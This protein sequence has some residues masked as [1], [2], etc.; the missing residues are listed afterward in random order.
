MEGTNIDLLKSLQTGF[1]NSSLDS[2]MELR[3]QLLVND[4]LSGRKVLTTIDHE[5]NNCEEFWF[6][7]AFITTGGIATVHQ[8]LIDLEKK[9]V[10]G[11]ILASQYLNFT[12]P[13]ALRKLLQFKNVTLKICDHGNFHGKGYLFKT[14]HIYNLIIGS[15]NFTSNALTSNKEL[16]IKISAGI[17][18][19]L[20]TSTLKE[21]KN[22][23]EKAIEVDEKFIEKY[24]S[25]YQK[26]KSS[27]TQSE[28][29]FDSLTQ[30][31]VMPNSMQKEALKNINNLRKEGKNKALLIS[32]TG[33][34]KTYL[35]AFDVK[36]FNPKKFLF[37]VHRK[38]IAE[39]ALRSF[40]RIFKEG[41]KSMGLFSGDR[42]EIEND[43]IFSTVQ[44]IA[45]EE[46]LKLFDPTYFDY[47]VIDE[48]HRAGAES[49]QRLLNYFNPE[50][51]L[52]MTATPE[53]TD[54]YDMFKLFDHN[55][56]YEIRLHR[57]L[58]EDMLAPFHY[59]GISEIEIEDKVI[60]EDAGFNLL[61]HPDRLNHI[62]ATIKK[63]GTDTGEIRGLVF[64]SKV[65]ECEWFSD[66]FNKAGY[67]TKA[68]SGNSSDKE[69]D[70]AIELL[71]SDDQREKLDYIFTRDI[72]NEGIDIPRVNQVIMLRPTQSA[73]VF[74][75]QLG[76]GLRKAF[77]KEYLTVIDFIGNYN[78]NFLVPI[79]L[80]GDSS[81]NKDSLRKFMSNESRFLPGESTISFDSIAK[82]RIYKAIDSANL[83]PYKELKKDYN[84]LKFK[85]NRIPNMADFLDHGSRDP[86]HYVNYNKSY[87]N[88]LKAI[89]EDIPT[90]PAKDEKLLEYLSYEINNAK[91][92]EE[93]YLLKIL[94]LEKSIT[95][96]EFQASIFKEFG[97]QITNETVA[98]AVSNINLNFITENYNRNLLPI[99]QIHGYHLISL[100]D[101]LISLSKSFSEVLENNCFKSQLEDSIQY[102]ILTYKKQFDL[103]QYKEGFMLYHKYARKDV[104]RILNW[105]QNPLAQNVGGYIISQDKSNCPIFVTYHKDENISNATKYEDG[106]KDN[107]VFEWMSKN[108]R[109]L[110]SP[111]VQSI[112]NHK[113]TNLR[114]PLFIKKS[115]AESDDFYYMGDL[116]PKQESFEQ[117]TINN[118]NG[119]TFSIVKI[120]FD[121][122]PAV[123]DWMLK[124]LNTKG[125]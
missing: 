1:I 7:V 89:N 110:N 5:L 72:F 54:G 53:R 81:Y 111:D 119:S 50:F 45:R 95:D 109:T 23:F 37:V 78:N 92:A 75:Q 104:F 28:E 30:R 65:E 41:I 19:E 61:L 73:I 18:S 33:T 113:A 118:D 105:K 66:Q 96:K 39:E 51:L 99:S 8:T 101:G 38:R 91:R 116:T 83:Q 64:C 10:K 112:K 123:E 6:S 25:I 90:I 97:F 121:I 2:R 44:T 46:N 122:Q 36:Q 86:F 4:F 68:L 16:N 14:N 108:K 115:N 20:I 27:N 120:I 70:A 79:A 85:L 60:E 88:F 13:E 59:Y 12:Q 74:V 57:A 100:E 76:R 80:Y 3:P 29:K 21:F 106:F 31:P 47:I 15:S 56:A 43:F 93:S 71:E 24:E 117:T 55:I 82:E 34:G 67:K 22:E 52:G 77:N 103:S 102:S 26:Q 48:T 17:Q 11:N 98:S 42:K 62:L 124:Y 40:Q 32:A 114:M 87:Y 125:Q 49:Y 107:H 84:L 63:F 69:R 35:S 9:G 58:E 94:V